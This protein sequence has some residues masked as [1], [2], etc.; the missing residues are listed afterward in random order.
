MELAKILMNL[1]ALMDRKYEI[2]N[3]NINLIYLI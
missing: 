1:Y 2:K 3:G